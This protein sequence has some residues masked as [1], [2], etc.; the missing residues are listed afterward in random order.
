MTK[1][2][3]YG[4]NTFDYSPATVRESVKNSL[5]RLQTDYLDT[6]YLHDVE[7]VCTQEFPKASGNHITALTTDATLYGLTEAD[8]GRI[9]DGGDQKIL[10]AISELRKLQDEGLVKNIGISGYP[11]PTLLRLA[12]LVLNQPP[13]KPLDV[14][15]SYCHLSLQNSTLT[16]YAPHFIER[17]RVGQL[18]TASP[19]SM[20]LLTSKPPAWHPAPSELHKV[21]QDCLAQCPLD[22]PNVAIGFSIRHTGTS[23]YNIPQVLG[24]STPREVHE[25]IKVWREINER[26][27][28]DRE[29]YEELIRRKFEEAGFKDWS[30]ASP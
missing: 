9:K 22:L 8:K 17:A 27:G 1:C 16:A 2:G 11:L 29:K 18:L 4:K 7:F 25:C 13:Y 15:L 21:V 12:I 10:D 6:V 20:G 30:W 3:R 19:L 14:L 24:L 5:R 28:A 26:S 23:H